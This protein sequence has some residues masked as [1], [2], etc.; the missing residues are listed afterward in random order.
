MTSFCFITNLLIKLKVKTLEVE[1]DSLIEANKTCAQQNLSREPL[2]RQKRQTLIDGHNELK[3]LKEEIDKKKSR[4]SEVS[5]QTSLDTRLALM[6]TATAEAEEQSEDIANSFLSNDMAFDLFIKEFIEKRK[7][8]HLRRI[9]TE[10]L[11]ECVRNESSNRLNNGSNS[12]GSTSSLFAP[13]RPAPPPPPSL[14]FATP[15]ANFPPYPVYGS[16]SMPQS[17]PQPI[18]YPYPS[19]R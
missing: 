8:S 18:N 17:M 16:Q 5:R 7:L 6:Q 2:Y 1:R 3:Q 14:P 15:A 12:V 19:Y 9:K 4:L 11:M 10:K 13:V